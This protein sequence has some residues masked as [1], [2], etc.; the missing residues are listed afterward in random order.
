MQMGIVALTKSVHPERVAENFDIFDFKLSEADIEK[1]EAL[2]MKHSAFF[3]HDA[4]EQV[5]WFMTRM[6]ATEE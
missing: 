4:A 6:Q 5:E 2:D 1:I 3:D